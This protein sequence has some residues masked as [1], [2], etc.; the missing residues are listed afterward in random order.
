MIARLQAKGLFQYGK[1]I[2]GLVLHGQP[3]PYPVLNERAVRAGAGIMFTLGLFAFFHAFYLHNFLYIQI[4][5]VVFFV[6]FIMKVVI[7]TRFSPISRIANWIV[8][9][10]SPEYVGA[11]QKRFA[12]GIGLTLATTMM[13]LMFGFGI[14]G[15]P[16]LIVCSLCLTFMFLETAFG[17]CVGCRIYN[18]LLEKKILPTPEYKP[19]CPG[20]VCADE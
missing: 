5:V 4:L 13:I 16:N 2:P 14:Q 19:A 20:N 3:A 17:V 15:V 11:T 7:G 8:K 10:Q 6:D 18:Y 9:N 1:V 12:W